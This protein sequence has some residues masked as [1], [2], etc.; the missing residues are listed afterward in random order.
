MSFRMSDPSL[1]TTPSHARVGGRG[2]VGGKVNFQTFTTVPNLPK[3]PYVFAARG[4]G[5]KGSML[6]V[7]IMWDIWW[8]FRVKKKVL[9]TFVSTQ[10]WVS[11]S[12]IVSLWRLIIWCYSGIVEQDKN[13]FNL[14]TKYTYHPSSWH[15]RSSFSTSNPTTLVKRQKSKKEQCKTSHILLEASQLLNEGS[16]ISCG[17]CHRF[18]EAIMIFLHI[19]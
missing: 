10:L 14:W 7:A 18:C 9:T 15:C 19:L 8:D 5:G 3:T 4:G 16:G 11:P 12:Q 17:L 13:I 1:I 6:N 2:W